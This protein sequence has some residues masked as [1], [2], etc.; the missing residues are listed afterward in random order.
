MC[1]YMHYIYINLY[2]YDI[3]IYNDIYMYR[4]H[5]IVTQMNSCGKAD[6]RWEPGAGPREA[7]VIGGLCESP[8]CLGFGTHENW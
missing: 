2:P 6:S 1:V 7:G 4:P 5:I 8:W 3:Y